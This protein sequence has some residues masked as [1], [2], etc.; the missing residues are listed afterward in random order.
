[1]GLH[2]VEH[3]Q[4]VEG[5]DKRLDRTREFALLDLIVE[6]SLPFVE[7]PSLSHQ[8]LFAFP[9]DFRLTFEFF[10]FREMTGL[11]DMSV[12]DWVIG[13]SLA[14]NLTDKLVS[15]S[16]VVLAHVFADLLKASSNFFCVTRASLSSEVSSLRALALFFLLPKNANVPPSATLPGFKGAGSFTCV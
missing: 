10:G 16:A 7:S 5:L 3:V 9:N 14:L 12:E 11:S 15:R 1:M 8:A 6:P 4:D 13:S 2:V